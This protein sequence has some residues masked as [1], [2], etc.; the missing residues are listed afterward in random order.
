[1]KA[2]IQFAA[3]YWNTLWKRKWRFFAAIA[4]SAILF[5]ISSYYLYNGINKRFMVYTAL[6]VT[7][8][9]FIVLPR[10]ERWY[11][12]LIPIVG[13]LLVVPRKVFERIELPVH[14][15]GRIQPG[16]PL[17][18]VMIVLLVYLLCLLV[19][20]RVRY[21]FG[22]GNI[23]LLIG[24]LVNY[25]VVQFRGTSLTANDIMAVGTAAQVVSNYQFTIGAEQW[26]S[27]LYFIC[28][29]LFGFWCDIPGKGLKYH[30]FS[31]TAAVVGLAGFFYFWNV[32]DYFEKYD[33]KGHYWN[34]SDNQELNGFLLS[35]G[36]GIKE[37]SMD[38]PDG[39]SDRMLLEIAHKTD[40]EYMNTSTD[41][42]PDIIFIM[43]EAW[44]DLKVL[45]N[46]V[47][48]EPYMPFVDSLDKNVIK[49]NLHVEVLGGLTANSEFEALTGDSLTF[50]PPGSIPYQLQ[51]KRDMYALPRVLKAQGY[52]TMAMHPSTGNAWRR[53]DVYDYFGFDEFIDIDKFGTEYLYERAFISDE[54]NYNEIIYQY[55]N[56]D[57]SKPWFLFNVTIQNHGDYYGGIDMPISITEIGG[58]QIQGYLYDA[59]TYLN[60]VKI[61]DGAF[62]KLVT[63]FEN[64]DTPTIIC[65]FGDHQP[66]LGNDFY[67]NIFSGSDLS[68]EEQTER[69]YITPYLIWANYDIENKEYGDMSANYLG[70][71]LAECAGLEL[72]VYYKYLLNLQKEYPVISSFTIN[73]IKEVDEVQQ[74]KM[75]QYNH[76]MEKEP[77]Q[78]LYIAE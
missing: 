69:K 23:L 74:Y 19:F 72:P 34:M 16:V 38:K 24:F 40:T 45:G 1:M 54:C 51:V 70:A 20:Q 46:L 37:G 57:T 6:C 73:E 15:M 29:I 75:L 26:Y 59:E 31:S 35:F 25:Y 8:G 48:S 3:E 43:N 52:E 71:V 50:L 56:R 44:S 62:E 14:D 76:L 9:I 60:L 63:Y 65:M 4:V 30:I 47:T 27:I 39:Y 21:A 67:N 55:E 11:L 58:G 18:N 53:D 64:V 49:G 77:L 66:S 10:I 12:S 41:V 33:L 13:Y 28:F 42:K 17:G 32:S 61:S 7:C 5:M 22:I 2:V 68:E 36:I 78:N